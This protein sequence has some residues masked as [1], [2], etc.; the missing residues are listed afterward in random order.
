[1]S[2]LLLA[3]LLAAAEPAPRCE[4]LAI[5]ATTCARCHEAECSGR[6]TFTGGPERA[7][8]HVRRYTGA[9]A[10]ERVDDLVELLRATKLDCRVHEAA[11]ADCGA[12]PGEA[13][14]LRRM[15]V[16]AE[17]AWFV[18]L[19]VPG[20][21]PRRLALRFD[22]DTQPS[23]R[24]STGG[25]ETL[26]ESTPTTRERVVELSFEAPAGQALFLRLRVDDEAKLVGVGW[27]DAP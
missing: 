5:F 20:A 9:L 22:R 6:L 15:H 7:R 23:V 27:L 13:Q 11:A 21:G 12:L 24:L 2:A 19:G 3:V 16:P 10:D 25:F 8:D 26:L 14:R 4:S 1:M 18:P 17:R